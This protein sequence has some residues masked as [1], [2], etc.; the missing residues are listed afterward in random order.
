MSTHYNIHYEGHVK[1]VNAAIKSMGKTDSF[2][3]F[4]ALTT[5]AEFHGGSV[6]SHGEFFTSLAPKSQGGGD[7]PPRG[8]K[9]YRMVRK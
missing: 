7:L 8:S 6:L 2:E 3:T 9:L 1:K 5:E 4:I